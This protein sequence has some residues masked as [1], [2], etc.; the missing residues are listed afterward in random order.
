MKLWD[1][2]SGVISLSIPHNRSQYDASKEIADIRRKMTYQLMGRSNA[3]SSVHL[4]L[5]AL[6]LIQFGSTHTFY[7]DDQAALQDRLELLQAL[8]QEYRGAQALRCGRPHLD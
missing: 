8:K 3:E 4:S 7:E 1:V 6:R 2:L 5:E